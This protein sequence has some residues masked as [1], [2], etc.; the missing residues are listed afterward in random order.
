MA[1]GYAAAEV[2]VV[3]AGQIIMDEREGVHALDGGG[4]GQRAFA[5]TTAGFVRREQEE[6]AQAF[7]SGKY[8]MPHRLVHDRRAGGGFGQRAIEGFLDGGAVAAEE[9]FQFVWSGGG[10]GK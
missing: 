6:R 8:R 10:H 4:E 9:V 5:V 3:H 2:I 7:A 1:G